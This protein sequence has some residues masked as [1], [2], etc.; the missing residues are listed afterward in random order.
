[1]RS[2]NIKFR[3]TVIEA[4][5]LLSADSNGLS[6]PYFYIPKQ[7]RGI[8]DLPKKQ[9]RT[10]TIM[11]TLNPVWNHNFDMEFS[12]QGTNKL[13]FEVYDY[14]YIGKD[15]LLGKGEILLDWM[16]L[17]QKDFFEEWVPLKLTVKDK[18][19]KM[20]QIT[21]KGSVH[22][23]LQIIYRPNQPPMGQQPY[24][25]PMGQ[26]PYQPPM[27][28]PP[29]Q[30]PPMP[31]GQPPMPPGQP[32]MQPGQPPM[33][34]GQ[35]PMQSGQPP[36]QP[37]QPPM[38]PA[39][40]MQPVPPGQPPMQPG[41]PPMQ[42]GQPP[43]QPAPPGQPPAQFSQPPPMGQPPAQYP[44]QQY[45]QPPPMGQP[46]AQFHRQQTMQPPAQ[47]PFLNR[48]G[49]MAPQP[50]PM[51]GQVPPRPQLMRQQTYQQPNY[52]PPMQPHG[53]GVPPMQHTMMTSQPYSVPHAPYYPPQYSQPPLAHSM[54]PM[55]RPMTAP[56]MPA[57]MM[58][59]HMAA[60]PPG[61]VILTN[62]RRGDELQPGSWIP[63]SEPTVLVGLGWDFTG[64]ETFDL[65]ASV[66]G[67]D[68]QF[69]VVDT[70]YFN[71][72]NGLSGSVIHFGDNLTG[73]G[74]GDDEVIK[75]ILHQVPRRVQYLAVTINSF[76]K[77]SLI[78]ARSAY[79]RLF[80]N[81]YH[82]GKYTLRRTKDCIGLLLG[83]FERSQDP[84]TWYFRVMADPIR[85]NKVTLSYE[86]IK[87][88][89][90]AYSIYNTAQRR[91]QHP[92]PGEP[93]IEFNKWIQLPNRFMYIGLGW[94]IQQGSNFDLDASIITF[95]RMNMPLEFIYH[96]NLRSY[97]GSI[98]HYG[99]NRT[100]LGEGD[101]E[102]LSIDFGHVDPN[103][104]TMAVVVNSFKGN[105]LVQV[106]DAFVRIYDTQ[107]PIG[108]HVMNKCPDCVGLCFG[109]FR[110]GMDGFWSFCAVQ[111]VV[112]GIE[113]TQSVNDLKLILDKHP[114]KA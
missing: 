89:L 36:M 39:P 10:K 87:A 19:T 105:S 73:E 110:K 64:G 62:F 56:V 92:L 18:K 112:S 37:G 14:D 44:P 35:P 81:T 75:V 45:S 60:M 2:Q 101:D 108:V 72:K 53:Y 41:Q 58:A 6:D 4:R 26:P 84:Y 78:R 12:P 71:H 33:Q 48:M 13:L 80:T 27:G 74:E 107:R 85:G 96:R 46:P 47:Q 51:P 24:P 65:D 93:L 86:D 55:A 40:P 11:K 20:N 97:N 28:Q 94:N 106:M 50:Q 99:D 91:V 79:I 82:I 70:I 113:C 77:N 90:G 17:G 29:T 1:M 16:S 69:N 66:T 100:G 21:Q 52:M 31:P 76:K 109:I 15:D 43:M 102:V 83:I 3:L 54:M 42:P 104:F 25:P 61:V 23:K 9:N 57:P 88:L 67:F 7:Q 38:Q 95:D 8:I 114:Y 63:V 5:D 68:F 22:I 32:P 111:D 34:P 49:T 59:P 103:V 30:Y 98:I